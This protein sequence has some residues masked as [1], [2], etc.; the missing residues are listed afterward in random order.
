MLKK[1]KKWDKGV[2]SWISKFN[3][4]FINKFMVLLTRL[5]DGGFVWVTIAISFLITKRYKSVSLKILLSLCLTT[6]VG[7]VVIKRLVGRL[8]PSQ[9]ISKEDLLI[10]KPT[11]Y[12]FPS[13][14]TASSFGVAV[15]L[16]EAFPFIN[17]LIFCLAS[18]IGIS[19]VYLKVH[20]PTDVIVG[21]IIGT[22]CGL[23]T[24]MIISL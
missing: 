8:R 12:S 5:G 13:G 1:I 11:S 4:P 16:S 23:V 21:A 3:N 7:E 20:Y 15:I 2:I 19:R 6:I 18:L 24:E 22:L 14:H 9:I 17:I 10:K